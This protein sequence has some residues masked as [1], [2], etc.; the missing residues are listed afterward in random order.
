MNAS[1][2]LAVTL[3]VAALAAGAVSAAPKS[4]GKAK[5]RSRSSAAATTAAGVASDSDAVLVRI[6]SGPGSDV[7]TPR[8]L[9]VRLQELPEQ[10][11]SQYS[12]PEGRKQL[13]DRLVEE[14][15]WL[16]DA[17]AHGVTRRPDLLLQIEAQKRDLLIRTWVN[18][19]MA[20]NP[21]P[22]DSEATVY[23]Q[24]HLDEW[25]TPAN[26]TLRHIQLKTEADGKRVLGLTKVKGANWDKLVKQF[27]GD[28]LTR[29][30]GGALGTAT[31]DGGFAGIGVQPALAESA[32][33]LGSGQIG[34]PYKT[35]KGWHVIKVDNVRAE[36]VRDF[37]QVRSFIVRQ[38]Q[39]E[40]TQRYYQDQLIRIKA[41]FRVQADSAAVKQWV[42]AR[43]TAREMF[44]EAQTQADAAQRIE[45]YRKLVDEY[46]DADVTPQAL[47]MIGFIHSE[48]MKDFD[49]AERVFRELLQKY[50]KSELASSA[51]WMV[52][53]MRTDEVPAFMNPDSTAAAKKP[54]AKGG[55]G[56][57]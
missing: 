6:G 31:K 37:D 2:L 27:S 36:T 13:L 55:G 22:S 52:E 49:G 17:E 54:A 45:T 5:S 40:R 42:S 3:A 8:M 9:N 10:Y 39:Q 30:A 26:V 4:S 56:K 35:D 46:P 20:K 51:H 33:A 47:F 29:N 25:K 32:M 21:A 23:Y 38:L 43:K 12:T 11:R 24:G 53:H 48:E 1:R 15:A 41:D 28:T 16:L 14:K 57:P 7:I 50:P 44:Q 18:E 19:V 34:G